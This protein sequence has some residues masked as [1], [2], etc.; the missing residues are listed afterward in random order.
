M[1][2]EDGNVVNVVDEVWPSQMVEM[3]N[4]DEDRGDE[5]MIMIETNSDA[6]NVDVIMGMG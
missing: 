4:V 5:D 3:G 2:K 1:N 6:D